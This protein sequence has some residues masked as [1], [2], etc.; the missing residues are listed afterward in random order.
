MRTEELLKQ[1]Q[2]LTEELQSQ[3]QELT[4]GNQRLEEQAR[5]AADFRRTAAAAAGRT[6]AHQQRAAGKAAQLAEQNAEVER[7][8][9]EV[10]QAKQAL[11]DKAEQLALISKYK[12]EF[13]ANMSH[14]LRTPLNSL[15][16]LA[17]V[18]AENSEGKLSPKQVKFAETIYS[19]GTDLLALINDILDLSKIESGMMAV[20]VEDVLFADVR[21]YVLRTFRHVAEGKGLQLQRRLDENCRR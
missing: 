4:E 17:K 19:A 21:D 15:L 5:D 10:E 18:L 2:A 14:E 20:E 8:N 1:S 7:K 6:A 11:E 13:L 12:S 9:R 3:Q 16:I